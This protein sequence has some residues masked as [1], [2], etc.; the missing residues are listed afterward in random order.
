LSRIQYDK[1]ELGPKKLEERIA[2]D[3]SV[4]Y[5]LVLAVGGRH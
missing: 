5:V 2:L 4:L 1:I 3:D